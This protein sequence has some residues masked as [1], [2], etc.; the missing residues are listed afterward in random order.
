MVNP[1]GQVDQKL[2]QAGHLVPVDA[3]H[4]SDPGRHDGPCGVRLDVSIAGG[5]SIPAVVPL[6][7][8]GRA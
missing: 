2:E 3:N 7:F 4:G 1:P 8:C 5:R 6:A